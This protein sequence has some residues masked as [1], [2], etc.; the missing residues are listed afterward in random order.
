MGRRLTIK[1]RRLGGASPAGGDEQP[2]VRSP[3]PAAAPDSPSGTKRQPPSRTKGAPCGIILVPWDGARRQRP[4]PTPFRLVRLEGSLRLQ[5]R[6][7]RGPPVSGSLVTSRAPSPPPARA[8]RCG[9]GPRRPRWARRTPSSPGG[10]RARSRSP[11][12]SPCGRGRAP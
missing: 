6:G 9:T 1:R 10:C 5:R 3:P 8:P 2:A 12:A 7:G 4:G 11:T